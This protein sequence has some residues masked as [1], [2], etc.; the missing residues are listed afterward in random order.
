MKMCNY[1]MAVLLRSFLFY[2]FLGSCFANQIFGFALIVKMR[3]HCGLIFKFTNK[4]RGFSTK[5][6]NSIRRI[7][8][9][10]IL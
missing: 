4:Y 10:A 3:L 5:I 2:F 9:I 1:A 6:V 8:R 7:V